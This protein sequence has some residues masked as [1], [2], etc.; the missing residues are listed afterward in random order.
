MK[1]FYYKKNELGPKTAYYIGKLLLLP[2]PSHLEHLCLHEVVC[3][4]NANEIFFNSLRDNRGLQTLRLSS[5]DL[6]KKNISD[7]LMRFLRLNNMRISSLQIR[8]SGL[9]VNQLSQVCHYLLR[10]RT[11]LQWL[12]LSD[13][14][15]R[16]QYMSR[17]V[18]KLTQVIRYCSLTHL[19]LSSLGLKKYAMKIA[20]TVRESK[21]LM[22]VHL[23][24]N[25][26][27]K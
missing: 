3:K 23:S 13:H 9:N 12:D 20:E 18:H 8:S 10:N 5:L 11:S 15:V 19:D 27:T 24:D 22:A 26:L 16:P 4:G 21:T 2:S 1:R 17:F 25:E 14:S 7:N 6:S